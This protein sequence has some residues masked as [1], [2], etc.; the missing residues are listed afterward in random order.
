VTVTLDDAL[1]ADLV[2]F[3]Q[4]LHQNPELSFQETRTAALIADRLHAEGFAATTEVGRTGVVGILRN[5]DGPT[6]ML[7]AEMDALPVQEATGLPYASTARGV[8]PAGQEVPVMHACGHDLHMTCLLGAAHVLAQDRRAWS[9]TLMLVFQ[10]AEEIWSGAR[11]MV[12][13]GLFDRF[14]RPDVVLAQHVAPA[15]AG[16]LGVSSGAAFAGADS[17][18]ITLFGRG[19]HAAL[20]EAT[21]DPVVMAAATVLRLQTIA[22][23]ELAGGE[24]AVVTVGALRAGTKENV[25]PDEAELLVSVRTIDPGVRDRVLAAIDRI[26]RAEAAA[27]RPSSWSPGTTTRQTLGRSPTPPLPPSG[28]RYCPGSRPPTGSAPT[29]DREPCATPTR[30]RSPTAAHRCPCRAR[31]T[32]S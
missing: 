17:L 28:P 1:H 24:M 25:I 12:D 23:R 14:V 21:V 9:G 32:T 5:G 30:W 27:S 3:Y 16:F 11:A 2:E 26:V 29:T 4:D 22:A 15:P 13:D 7:R 18:R 20:P 6:A 19:G 10:P 31:P 8:D